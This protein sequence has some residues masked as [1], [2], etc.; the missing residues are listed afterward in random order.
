[1]PQHEHGSVHQPAPSGSE[2]KQAT[3]DV[4]LLGEDVGKV[5]GVFRVTAR[6]LR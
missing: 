4:V 2:M 6:A 1:M 5:G 3:I